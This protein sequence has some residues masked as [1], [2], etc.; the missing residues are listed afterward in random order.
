MTTSEKNTP[1]YN[2]KTILK[3]AKKMAKVVQKKL[4]TNLNS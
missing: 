4:V 3:Y 2:A 1:E